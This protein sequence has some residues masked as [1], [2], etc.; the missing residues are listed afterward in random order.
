MV[1]VPKCDDGMPRIITQTC[2]SERNRTTTDAHTRRRVEPPAGSRLRCAVAP[3][4]RNLPP[5]PLLLEPVQMLKREDL[6]GP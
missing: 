5:P 4:L 1:L 3:P 6:P 2:Q